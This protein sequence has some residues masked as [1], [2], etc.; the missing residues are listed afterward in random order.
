MTAISLRWRRW[1]MPSTSTAGWRGSSWSYSG[2]HARNN[3]TRATALGVRSFSVPEYFP[4]QTRMADKEDLYTLRR[5][6]RKAALRA[7]QAGFDII[8]C[9]AG[10]TLSIAMFMLLKRYNQ[11]TDEYG[12][13]LENRTRLLRELLEDTH[14]AVGDSCAVALR[15]AVDELL[16][17]DRAD[18]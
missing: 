3:F 13:S 12:G 7:K 1:W 6:H 4:A 2:Q 18:P 5:W 8:Y 10:H 17:P 15:L 16:G 11:R 14:D 9:Y